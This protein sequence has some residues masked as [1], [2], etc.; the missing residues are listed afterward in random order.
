MLTCHIKMEEIN[1]RPGS[2]TDSK[3][4]LQACFKVYLPKFG[5]TNSSPPPPL[6]NSSGTEGSPFP[7]HSDTPDA[8]APGTGPALA[9]GDQPPQERSVHSYPLAEVMFLSPHLTTEHHVPVV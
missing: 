6:C 8:G 3:G 9:L 7:I 2:S 4:R 5:L 1:N